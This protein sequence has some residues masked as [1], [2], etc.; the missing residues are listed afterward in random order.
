MLRKNKGHAAIFLLNKSQRKGAHEA[1]TMKLAEED[2][3]VILNFALP[4]L[5]AS[6][7]R[8]LQPALLG[9]RPAAMILR[10]VAGPVVRSP[11]PAR[12]ED[13]PYGDDPR[14]RVDAHKVHDR[15]PNSRFIDCQSSTLQMA[16][17]NHAAVDVLDL[18]RIRKSM[19]QPLQAVYLVVRIAVLL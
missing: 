15:T 4:I 9:R 6:P 18:L 12:D 10:I 8:K 11:R 5:H 3:A 1:P 16:T 14:N 17:P 7:A 2:R 13:R 19:R